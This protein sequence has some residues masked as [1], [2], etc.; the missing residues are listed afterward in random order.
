[1]KNI[2]T[3]I[4]LLTFLAIISSCTTFKDAGYKNVS[5]F[6]NLEHNGTQNEDITNYAP[7]KIQSGDILG[8]NV[9]SVA[10]PE[11]AAA[12]AVFNTTIVKTNINDPN[13]VNPVYGFRVDANGNVQLPYVGN[14]KVAGMNTD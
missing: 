8:I 14:M 12:A 2:I 10:S 4:T 6:Q 3:Q 13:A 11:A 1:M 9:N 5:Y 7:F